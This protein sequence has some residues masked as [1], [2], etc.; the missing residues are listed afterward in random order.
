MPV[1]SGHANLSPSPIPSVVH[2]TVPKVASRRELREL[3]GSYARAARRMADAGLDAVEVQTAA[4]YILGSFLSPTLN[5]RTDE[6]GGSAE[7]R[8]RYVAEV[9]EDVR[10]AVEG[11]IAV[12]VRTSSAHQIAGDPMG[13]GVDEAIEAMAALAA[14]SLIDW[15]S[16]LSGSYWSAPLIIAP[17]GSPRTGAAAE[18]AAFKDALDVPVIVAGRIRTPEEAERV[19]TE[20]QADVVALGRA[21][22]ADPDWVARAQAGEAER[23]RPC[24][25]CNQGCWASFSLGAPVSCIVNPAAGN[26]LALPQPMAAEAPRRVAVIG[27]GPA[28]LET[29]RVAAERGH[30]VVLYEA[31][32]RLGGEFALAADAPHRGEMRL[33]VDWWARELERL[34][35]EVRLGERIEEPP[36]DA[37]EVVWAVGA[38][39]ADTAVWRFRPALA[40]GIPG[41][42]G[43]PHGRDVLAG[44]A[45]V[46]GSVLVIDEEG[47]WA[48]TSL[49]EALA[50]DPQL[51]AVTVV[52][53]A[54][55]LGHPELLHT[56]E[57]FEVGPRVAAAGVT[58]LPQ[59]FVVA[60]ADGG[61]E[62][63]DGGRIG[64]FDAI[65]L[66]T[67][68]AAPELDDDALAVGDC[69]A[70]RGVWAATTD[71]A[72]LGRAL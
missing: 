21:L 54:P 20:G 8:V 62:L 48:A 22:L 66:S 41:T 37:D 14:R 33:A 47:G 53:S 58:V 44:R 40:E 63:L 65:V 6:Y 46:A 43:L 28:G 68:T 27:G 52:T 23:I 45:T 51:E 30:R 3:R 35:V 71:A 64:P 69:V 39:P 32:G 49:A 9:L 1:R 17:M 56:L 34:D 60:V 18:A 2:G 42:A 72:R 70:P 10:E 29:A 25:S 36:A 57:I 16:I 59:A 12:A 55:A 13:Y 11:R 4:D 15:V 50:A 19:L 38:T 67:G 61:A 26:E 31:T 5:R 24:I 7:N